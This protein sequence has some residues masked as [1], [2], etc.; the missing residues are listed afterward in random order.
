MAPYNS[1]NKASKILLYVNNMR[2]VIRRDVL[3]SDCTEEF[4]TPS[5]PSPGDMVTI[6]FRTYRN[7]PDMVYLCAYDIIILYIA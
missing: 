4:V 3:F 1:L 6:R 2:A 5:E 7:N